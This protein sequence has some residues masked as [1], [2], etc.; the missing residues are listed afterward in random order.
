M[1]SGA[2]QRVAAL[3]SCASA[4]ASRVGPALACLPAAGFAMTRNTSMDRAHTLLVLRRPHTAGGGRRRLRCVTRPPPAESRLRLCGE[5]R[6]THALSVLRPQDTSV[7]NAVFG[8]NISDRYSAL[9]E[10]A[11]GPAIGRAAPLSTSARRLPSSPLASPALPDAQSRPYGRACRLL[12]ALRPAVNTSLRRCSRQR[13]RPKCSGPPSPSQSSSAVRTARATAAAA[14]A[15][16][17]A[18]PGAAF[19]APHLDPH[20]RRRS[21]GSFPC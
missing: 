16:L 17:L 18:R 15:A 12:L 21:D 9:R 14:A 3:L 11:E 4:E 8:K 20:A 1:Q 19:L 10:C 2:V 5:R 6:L 13:A 7:W